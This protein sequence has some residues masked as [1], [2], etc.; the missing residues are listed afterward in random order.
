MKEIAYGMLTVIILFILL[1]GYGLN[2]FV[3]MHDKSKD[4]EIAILQ[5]EVNALKE[6]ERDA[7]DERY[8]WYSMYTD[9]RVENI[10]KDSTIL[11]LQHNLTRIELLYMQTYDTRR[12]KK[13]YR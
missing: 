10:Q 5:G 7:L 13:D 2:R 3:P 6:R 4:T 12:S 9:L 1:M 8:K 11:L